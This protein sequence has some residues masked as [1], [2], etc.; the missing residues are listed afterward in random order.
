MHGGGELL[1]T[2]D[3][4]VP[5]GR[6][7]RPDPLWCRGSRG[8]GRRAV[9]SGLDASPGGAGTGLLGTPRQRACRPRPFEAALAVVAA[10]GGHAIGFRG[11]LNAAK[12]PRPGPA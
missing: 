3:R 10:N 8:E 2:V 1:L 7:R 9:D 6:S 12:A 5:V 11:A 4:F